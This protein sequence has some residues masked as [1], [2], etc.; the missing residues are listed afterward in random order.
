MIDAIKAF[1]DTQQMLAD[2]LRSYATNM[3][4]TADD[5]NQRI[6]ALEA[7]TA[8]LVRLIERTPQS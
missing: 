7:S 4:A 6:R 5:S 3:R 8:A 2:V 1:S